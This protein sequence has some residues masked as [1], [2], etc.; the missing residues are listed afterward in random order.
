[1]SINTVTG[2]SPAFSWPVKIPSSLAPGNYV[3]RHE[4]IA[5]HAAG[6]SN[7]AQNY[8]QVST[9]VRALFRRSSLT[10]RSASTSK[11][12]AAAPPRPAVYRPPHFT[13]RPTLASSSTSTPRSAATLF[14][15]RPS[16]ALRDVLLMPVTGSFPH[17]Q[18]MSHG[19]RTTYRQMFGDCTAW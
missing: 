1:M 19:A 7:G 9:S 18:S 13:R 6:S 5:L 10:S 16:R 4:I 3:I 12:P 2:A 17:R 8:P 15:V 11:S 14:P